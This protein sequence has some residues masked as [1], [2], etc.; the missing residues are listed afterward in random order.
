MKQITLYLIGLLISTAAI[1]DPGPTPAPSGTKST[2]SKALVNSGTV[3]F[4][5]NAMPTGDDHQDSV[6]V[7][8]D[9][10][11]HTGAGI[12]FQV[13]A[14]DAEH[15]ITISTIPAGKYFVTVQCKGLHRD[16]M[17]MLVNVKSQKNEKVRIK[18]ED[19]EVFSKD[20]VKIPAYRPS[21]N[22]LTI[23]KDSN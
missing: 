14:T 1:A 3:R 7:I 23:L 2:A 5:F 11:D 18:L 6:L 15:G 8:F 21:F 13:F 4:Q 9:R 22:D 19:S 20:N 17:E 10:Y 16:H 12:I